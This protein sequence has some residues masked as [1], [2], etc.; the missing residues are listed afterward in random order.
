MAMT[1]KEQIFATL[2]GEHCS[3]LP[4]VPRLDNWY[5]ANKINGTLP[6]RFKNASLRELTDELGF[7]FHAINPDYLDLRV[8]DGKKNIGIGIYDIN[9]TPYIVTLENVGMTVEEEPNGYT[10]VTYDTPKGKLS[11]RF[12]YDDGMHKGGISISVITEH[13]VKS[14]KDF[15]A[16]AYI[17]QNANIN[18]NY[19]ML[20]D[21]KKNFIGERGLTVGL[22]GVYC[23]PLHYMLRELMSVDSFYIEMIEYQDEMEEF[24]AQVQPYFDRTFE[25]AANSPADAVLCGS[26]FDCY[27]TAPSMYRDYMLPHLQ[28]RSK[29][30]EDMGKYLICHT[31]GE[32]RGLVDLFAQ[33]GFHIADSICPAPMTKCT[34]AEIREAFDG[35]TTIWG[36]VPSICMLNETVS[37]YDFEK[38][39]DDM[40]STI[41]RGDHLIVS[42]ADTLPPAADFNRVMHLA[43]KISEFGPISPV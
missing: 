27:V 7:G 2:K 32:N 29:E 24:A 42:I 17:L 16:M 3:C 6:D 33:S 14:H 30:L 22:A 8:P 20:A 40:L 21:F 19:E 26:N 9:L 15:A 10:H 28:K 11:T 4:F 31:D 1:I 38:Y 23:S 34:L 35:K 5:L 37:K 25:L 43:K 13:I 12:V 39:V 18:P 41:G 36:G